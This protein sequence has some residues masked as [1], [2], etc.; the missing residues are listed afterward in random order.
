MIRDMVLL[1]T[2]NTLSDWRH[3][4]VLTICPIGE[5]Q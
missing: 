4:S 1:I 2:H 3:K 5:G